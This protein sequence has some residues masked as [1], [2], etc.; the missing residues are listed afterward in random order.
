MYRKKIRELKMTL[1]TF[2]C[3][4]GILSFVLYSNVIRSLPL[5]SLYVA[6][7]MALWDPGF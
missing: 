7:L 6:A 2:W 1:L 3:K 5:L 4:N